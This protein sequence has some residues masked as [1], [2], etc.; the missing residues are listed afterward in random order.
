MNYFS[1]GWWY[2]TNKI[3]SSWQ[4]MEFCLGHEGM[5]A[6]ILL[7]IIVG[8]VSLGFSEKKNLKNWT[9]I[10]LPL[11]QMGMLVLVLLGLSKWYNLFMNRYFL[12]TLPCVFTLLVALWMVL[13]RRWTGFIVLLPLFLYFNTTYY[14]NYSLPHVAEYT[15]LT[16]SFE[17]VSTSLQAQ[18]VLVLLDPITY[19]GASQWPFMHY[20]IP[21]DYAPEVLSLTKENAPWVKEQQVPLI[22]PLCSF[23]RVVMA[24]SDYGFELPEKLISFKQSCVVYLPK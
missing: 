15:G 24:S 14:F 17:Y 1:L 6:G 11:F 10:W 7:L 18:K 4:V 9:T 16:Q 5:L 21:G 22:V 23:Y 20:F 3:L 8:L 12:I 13:Y 2:E 19:P